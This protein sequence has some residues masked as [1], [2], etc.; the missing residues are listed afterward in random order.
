MSR[1]SQIHMDGIVTILPFKVAPVTGTPLNLPENADCLVVETITV[2]AVKKAC[3]DA[4]D[5]R[6][7]QFTCVASA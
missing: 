1:A 7:Q 6:K 2:E 5:A 4:R 3:F